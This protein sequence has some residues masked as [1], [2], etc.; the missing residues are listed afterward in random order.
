MSVLVS[1]TVT[2]SGH[3]T[4]ADTCEATSEELAW[5]LATIRRWRTEGRVRTACIRCGTERAA[6]QA[7]ASNWICTCGGHI[8]V[9]SP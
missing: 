9:V 6:A 7:R 5:C 2:E 4:R 3:R 8:A 1:I